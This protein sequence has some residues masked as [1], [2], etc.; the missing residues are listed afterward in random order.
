MKQRALFLLLVSTCLWGSGCEQ[1]LGPNADRRRE[2]AQL[3]EASGDYP[4]A[5][6]LYETTFSS[7]PALAAELHYKLG[8]LYDDKLQ[9]PADSLHHFQRYLLLAPQGGHARDAKRFA[10][11]AELQLATRL[12]VGATLPQ[13][14]AVRLKNEN[15]ELQK[16]VMELRAELETAARLRTQLLKNAG[17]RG[18]AAGRAGQQV[19]KPLIPGV[20]TYTVVSGDTLA[21]IAR[22]VYKNP[23]RWRDIQD[24]NFGAMQGTARLQPGMELMIP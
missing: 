20:R 11:E 17:V 3:K 22:K 24:A 9:S 4:A 13:P 14:V 10:E 18:G 1:L 5:I 2:S 12:G 8:L 23:E 7:D 21:T 16:K 19:Q 15:L 6:A